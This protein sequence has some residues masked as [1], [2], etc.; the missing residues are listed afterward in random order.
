MAQTHRESSPHHSVSYADED[1]V[2]DAVVD[3]DE[4][5]EAEAAAGRLEHALEQARDCTA[6]ED[7][8]H[9]CTGLPFQACG[10]HL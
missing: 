9:A 10:H 8:A 2:E 4:D 1:E 7:T 3:V 6:G 5:G